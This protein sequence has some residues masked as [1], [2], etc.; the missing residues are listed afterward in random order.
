MAKG[1]ATLCSIP[2]LLWRAGPTIRR[3]ARVRPGRRWWASAALVAV[4]GALT[5][6]SCGSS[7]GVAGQPITTTTVGSAEGQQVAAADNDCAAAATTLDSLT[8]LPLG[9]PGKLPG[10][11]SRILD[12]NFLLVR[13]ALGKLSR[14]PVTGQ[15]GNRVRQIDSLLRRSTI[16]MQEAVADARSGKTTRGV[17]LE[18][19]ARRELRNAERAAASASLHYCATAHGGTIRVQ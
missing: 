16:V 6:S 13:Q 4:G 19:Q 3:T 1:G 9:A 5:L 15:E 2:R 10:S 17:T 18:G 7:G 12:A 11:A 14:V 8:R